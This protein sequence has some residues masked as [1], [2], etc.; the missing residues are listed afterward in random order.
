MSRVTRGTAMPSFHK[1][2]G[3]T[4]SGPTL[5]A[6]QVEDVVAYLATLKK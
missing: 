5:S 2:G 1:S 4:G 6:E 3:L